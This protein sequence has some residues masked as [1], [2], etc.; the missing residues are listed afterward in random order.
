[1]HTQTYIYTHGIIDCTPQHQIPL[2]YTLNIPLFL[3]HPPSG[4][5]SLGKNSSTE[6]LALPRSW[7]D[8][9]C[10]SQHVLYMYCRNLIS[11]DNMRG[12][13]RTIVIDGSSS[14][15][16]PCGFCQMLLPV[17]KCSTTIPFSIVLNS[18]LYCS[19]LPE[20]GA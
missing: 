14:V 1:M 6:R 3:H 5:R 11:F 2:W 20:A 13:V 8:P 19:I 10:F 4:P 9:N 18:L 12:D 16:Q 7:K 15:D 17:L